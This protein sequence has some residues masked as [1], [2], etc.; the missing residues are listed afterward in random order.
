MY[1]QN[2]EIMTNEKYYFNWFRRAGRRLFI[3]T[4][5]TNDLLQD[6]NSFGNN[7]IG[8][9][10]LRSAPMETLNIWYDGFIWKCWLLLDHSVVV[11][12]QVKYLGFKD[13]FIFRLQRFC[14][15]TLEHFF[16]KYYVTCVNDDPSRTLELSYFKAY[17][18]NIYWPYLKDVFYLNFLYCKDSLVNG[19]L[20]TYNSL[21]Y[22]NQWSY[23]IFN[24]SYSFIY[25]P[26]YYIWRHTFGQAWVTLL[27]LTNLIWHW[28]YYSFSGGLSFSRLMASFG[29]SF[30]IFIAHIYNFFIQLKVMFV[31]GCKFYFEGIFYPFICLYWYFIKSKAFFI[32]SFMSNYGLYV[33]IFNHS[34]ICVYVRTLF[35]DLKTIYCMALGTTNDLP[36]GSIKVSLKE[37]EELVQKLSV[38]DLYNNKQKYSKDVVD[39]YEKNPEAYVTDS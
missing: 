19:I 3:E 21:F 20:H 16:Y 25:Y 24:L 39:T 32:S 35:S 37:S 14:D 31:E 29:Y 13:F 38:S 5:M 2:R 11:F 8:F 10:K 4:R 30:S 33:N 12:N 18:E 27:Y 22:I 15:K 7:L 9:D 17:V 28:D 26:I 23:Y 34:S 1:I 36:K 6:L